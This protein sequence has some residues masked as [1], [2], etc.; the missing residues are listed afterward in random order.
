MRGEAGVR[1]GGCEADTAETIII[2]NVS[3][4][5]CVLS[6]ETVERGTGSGRRQEVG[7]A[8]AIEEGDK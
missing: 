7:E 1:G 4:I 2:I 8:A 6:C 3:G 5:I